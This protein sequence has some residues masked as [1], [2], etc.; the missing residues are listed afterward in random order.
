MLDPFSELHAEPDREIH[1]VARVAVQGDAEEQPRP[2][3]GFGQGR[4]EI[5]VRRDL[6]TESVGRW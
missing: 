5:D 6:L 1:R 3:R 4:A 2:A